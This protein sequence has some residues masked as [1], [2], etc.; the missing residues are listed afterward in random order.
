M[1]KYTDYQLLKRCM[2]EGCIFTVIYALCL[3]AFT[4][5]DTSLEIPFTQILITYTAY[6]LMLFVIKRFLVKNSL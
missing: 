1:F 5:F 3:W 2:V 6:V 4:G